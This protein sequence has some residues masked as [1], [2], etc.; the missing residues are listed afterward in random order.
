MQEQIILNERGVMVS[1]ARFVTPRA[2]YAIGQVTSVYGQTRKPETFWPWL[3][4]VLGVLT[5][6]IVVGVGILIAGI[7]WL[8]SMK[9]THDV[10][11]VTS[12]GQ[13]PA[14]SDL[15]FAFVQR[16]HH[17]LNTAIVGRG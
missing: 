14:L 10:Y 7:L 16:V 1:T 15:D 5:I 8:R 12:A 6:P 9:P 3:V 13:V 2:T 4:I 17:A 11:V